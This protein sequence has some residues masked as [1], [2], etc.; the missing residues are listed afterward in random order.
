MASSSRFC[1]CLARAT[2]RIPPLGS[3]ST[4]SLGEYY[5]L[6]PQNAVALQGSLSATQSNLP[7]PASDN[8]A[9]HSTGIIVLTV[10]FEVSQP[11]GSYVR[12][13]GPTQEHTILFFIATEGLLDKF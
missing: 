6:F 2:G 7:L 4:S 5:I 12:S 8:G 3:T 1:L 11:E 9:R 10:S 13:D